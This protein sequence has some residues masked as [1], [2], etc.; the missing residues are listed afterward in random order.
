MYVCFFAYFKKTEIPCTF[1]KYTPLL[2]LMR[3]MFSRG[4]LSVA[5][6]IGVG[7]G[8]LKADFETDLENVLHTAGLGNV[9]KNQAFEGY[10]GLYK[11]FSKNAKKAL[12]RFFLK[13]DYSLKDVFD[14]NDQLWKKILELDAKGKNLV[15]NDDFLQ[16]ECHWVFLR[17]MYEFSRYCIR[18]YGKKWIP[19][20]YFSADLV[21]DETVLSKIFSPFETSGGKCVVWV[22]DEHGI[23]EEIEPETDPERKKFC[24]SEELR[25]NNY[26]YPSVQIHGIVSRFFKKCENITDEILKCLKKNSGVSPKENLQ[27]CFR[28]KHP[29][30]V[31][32]KPSKGGKGWNFPER[33]SELYSKHLN[34]VCYNS[35]YKY[36]CEALLKGFFYYQ[37]LMLNMYRTG[38]YKIMKELGVIVPDLTNDFDTEYNQ[39]LFERSHSVG[40]FKF[41]DKA[42]DTKMLNNGFPADSDTTNTIQQ[43]TIQ[44]DIKP[45][46]KR[47]DSFRFGLKKGS[48]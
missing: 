34:N 20:E 39:L 42:V 14:F 33:I 41:E 5:V 2:T 16:W 45:R 30:A 25:F 7:T 12:R 40:E 36:K 29:A 22:Q 10:V 37:T 44:E 23:Y 15:K 43:N 24:V 47:S 11:D 4:V 13:K 9:T 21:P 27:V 38:F 35:L 28:F 31:I 8:S 46:L 3:K 17:R 18:R 48:L 1:E 19:K 26:N 32:V 6:C